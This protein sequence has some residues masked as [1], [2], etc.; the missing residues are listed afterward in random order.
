MN[1]YHKFKNK[2]NLLLT[3][4]C[5]LLPAT[6]HA[7]NLQD[8]INA[9]QTN[10][11]NIKLEQIKLKATKTIKT[12][13]I[14]EFLPNVSVNG[15]YGNKNETFKGQT[16]DPS[17]KQRVEEI[18]LD[19]P[20]FD[21][22]H[23]VSKYREA[24][25]KIKSA[26][27]KTSDKIQEISFAAVQSYC[28]LF[29]YLELEKLQKENKNLA[30]KFMDLVQRRKD[31]LIIDKGDIIKF[32]YEASIN[33]EK[34]WDILN[35]L[36]KAKFDYKNVVGEL[37]QNLSEPKITEED[38][39]QNKVLETALSDNNSIK[40]SHY[41]YLASKASYNAAKSNFS[42]KLSL[43]A[44]ASKQ[45]Q[46]VYLNNQDL[47]S[48][49]IFLNV[50]VPIFQKGTE[51]AGLARAGYEKE[52]ALEEYEITKDSVAKEVNQTLEEYHFYSS[53][54]KS[55]KKLWQMAKSREEIFNKRLKSKIEDPIEV[56][57]TK[58]ETNERKINYIESQMN[59]IITYYKIKYFLG[60]I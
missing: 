6:S 36:N 38:F 23:S 18:K 57:R 21:G 28:N 26:K 14:A 56:I 31:V 29:R 54:N 27:S 1:F 39:N 40:S 4:T 17:T 53:M 52:A 49:S 45:D 46:V 20:L 33:D 59:L 48:R 5:L 43:S 2:L 9:S 16:A 7:T 44:S 41:D 3:A 58:I 24:N 25:Y 15:Q 34:Y 50:S 8:A 11:R 13:A 32:G 35:K 22:F 19:Q 10:N 42:P 55:N 60:E 51:Y 12:E 47:N 30:K 37:H